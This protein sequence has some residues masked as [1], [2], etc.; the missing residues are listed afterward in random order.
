MC[1]QH[2]CYYA[3]SN[4]VSAELR[5]TRAPSTTAGAWSTSRGWTSSRFLSDPQRMA[6]SR[7]GRGSRLTLQPG[8]STWAWVSGKPLGVWKFVT[9]VTPVAQHLP[10]SL[11]N[12]GFPVLDFDL[13]AVFCSKHRTS[14]AFLL[15]KVEGRWNNKPLDGGRIRP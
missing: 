3:P 13:G 2:W 5:S 1:F 15:T 12:D 11:S 6:S 8:P 4:Q 10:N 14:N 7:S 9:V